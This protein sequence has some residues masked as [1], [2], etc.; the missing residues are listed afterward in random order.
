MYYVVAQCTQNLK[1]LEP[2]LEKAEQHAD[3]KKF[4]VGVLMN[5]RLA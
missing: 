1:N 2:C 5:S 4:D 3:T